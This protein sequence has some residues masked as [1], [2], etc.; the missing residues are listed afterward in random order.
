MSDNH[1][2]H[3]KASL[4]I[5]HTNECGHWGVKHDDKLR[6]LG[7]KLLPGC[8]CLIAKRLKQGGGCV[9]P[10]SPRFPPANQSPN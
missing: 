9:D 2:Q 6:R 1:R 8:S 3:M 5:C 10:D 7:C 4:A